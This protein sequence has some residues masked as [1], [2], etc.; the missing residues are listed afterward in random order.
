MLTYEIIRYINDLDPKCTLSYT[1]SLR[2]LSIYVKFDCDSQE[3]VEVPMPFI[4][5]R[6]TETSDN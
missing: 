2:N 1:I 4:L 5:Q 3:L 6:P